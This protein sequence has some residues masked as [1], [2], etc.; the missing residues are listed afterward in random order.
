MF[1]PNKKKSPAPSTTHSGH[2]SLSPRTVTDYEKK[3]EFEATPVYALP[4]DTIVKIASTAIPTDTAT[5]KKVKSVKGESVG[6][7]A[8][9]N[10]TND[11]RDTRNQAKGGDTASEAGTYTIDQVF[12]LIINKQNINIEKYYF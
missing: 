10:I 7:D 12:H 6:V 3:K 11:T 1:A 8:D 9:N 5:V 2:A 4:R